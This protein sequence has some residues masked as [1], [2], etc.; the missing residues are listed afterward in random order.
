MYLYLYSP[1]GPARPIIGPN[2]LQCRWSCIEQSIQMWAPPHKTLHTFAT[3]LIQL[4]CYDQ[5]INSMELTGLQLASK[6]PTLMVPVFKRAHT[7]PIHEPDQSSPSRSNCT[8]KIKFN[9]YSHLHLV[10]PSGFCPSEFFTKTLFHLYS[11]PYVLHAPPISLF[12]FGSF[13]WFLR[14]TIIIYCKII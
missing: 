12:F 8:L 10:L 5:L 11:D 14:I 7:Y 6:F 1:F 9:T 3:Q 4:M 13:E 2:L